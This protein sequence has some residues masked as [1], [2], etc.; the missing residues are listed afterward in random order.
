MDRFLRQQILCLVANL[1]VFVAGQAC[2]QGDATFYITNSGATQLPAAIPEL[3]GSGAFDIWV[4]TPFDFGPASLEVL[5]RGDAVRLTH[6]TVYN[7]VVDGLRRWG[8][9]WRSP[10]L[11]EENQIMDMGGYISSGCCPGAGI[12]PYAQARGDPEYDAKADAFRWATIHYEL[13][14]PA[15]SSQIWLLNDGLS[16][17]DGNGGVFFGDG[18]GPI[19]FGESGEIPDAI[20]LGVPEP[21]GALLA[22]LALATGIA[23]HRRRFV[24]VRTLN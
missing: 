19:E 1:L 11:A 13:I 24:G 7:P 4:R 2:A 16:A 12:G 17:Y 3:D 6:A 9:L 8:A 15:E 21:T 20:F 5:A 10:I 22:G 18:D 23:A 14:G